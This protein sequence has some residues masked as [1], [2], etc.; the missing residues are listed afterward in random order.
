MLMLLKLLVMTKVAR[1]NAR[2]DLEIFH[3]AIIAE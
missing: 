2:R 3:F 1:K